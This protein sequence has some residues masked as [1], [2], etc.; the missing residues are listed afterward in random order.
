MC[1]PRDEGYLFLAIEKQSTNR[2]AVVT[3]ERSDFVFLDVIFF[4]PELIL[5]APEIL[6][7]HFYF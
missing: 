6:G 4:S 1:I 7:K 3:V 2:E 5:H